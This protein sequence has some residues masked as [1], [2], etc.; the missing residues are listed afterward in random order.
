LQASLHRS[1][2]RE[3]PHPKGS[4]TGQN[5]KPFLLG[6][7]MLAFTLGYGPPDAGGIYNMSKEIL[8]S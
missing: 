8:K 7:V 5:P 4:H 6:Y 3:G 1:S 2:N